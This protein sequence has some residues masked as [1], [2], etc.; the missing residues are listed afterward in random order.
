MLERLPRAPYMRQK[1]A[2]GLLI[3][4]ANGYHRLGAG[5]IIRMSSHEGESQ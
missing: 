3:S 5:L 4:Q 2:E 1:V